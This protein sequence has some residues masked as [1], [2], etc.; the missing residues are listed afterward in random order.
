MLTNICTANEVLFRFETFLMKQ[1][2]YDLDHIRSLPYYPKAREL[3]LEDPDFWAD[4]S[5]WDLHDEANLLTK[6]D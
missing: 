2:Q 6:K 4:R 1:F 5:F 3:I